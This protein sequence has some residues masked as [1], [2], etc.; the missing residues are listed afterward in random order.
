MK[1]LQGRRY[2]KPLFIY[3]RFVGMTINDFFSS[4]IS[5][6]NQYKYIVF[7]I[8]LC[9][10]FQMQEKVKA[11]RYSK[12]IFLSSC[13]VADNSHVKIVWHAVI[14]TE[15]DTLQFWDNIHLLKHYSVKVPQNCFNSYNCSN[16]AGMQI[17]KF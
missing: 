7:N 13:F 10:I 16:Q 11:C 15:H 4:D 9:R 3:S 14:F 8:F 17:F 1:I 12:C 6:W 5:L 2:D